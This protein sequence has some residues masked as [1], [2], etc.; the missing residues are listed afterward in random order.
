MQSWVLGSNTLRK[1][2]LS[3]SA[4]KITSSF[5]SSPL[6][7]VFLPSF[8]VLNVF[9]GGNMRNFM[10]TVVKGKLDRKH[11]YM[12]QSLEGG[13]IGRALSEVEG[14][15]RMGGSEG[16]LKLRYTTRIQKTF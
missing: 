5:P 14:E 9:L 10:M 8:C 4:I 15:A 7:R 16:S 11:S 12:S 13:F 6:V 1:G 2:L 3:L